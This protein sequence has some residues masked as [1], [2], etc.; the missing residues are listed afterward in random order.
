MFHRLFFLYLAIFLCVN[1][2][3]AQEPDLAF[4][5]GTRPPVSQLRHFEQVV[6]QPNQLLPEDEHALMQ[7]GSL[8][9]AYVSVGEVA[10]NSVDFAAIDQ[11]WVIG[12]N[13][14]WDSLVMDYRAE[15][16]RRYLVEK[17]FRPLWQ[18]GYRA[19]FLDTMDSYLLVEKAG[20]GRHAQEAGLRDLLRTIKAEFA[21][22]KVIVNRGFDV[23]DAAHEYIDRLVA[24][25]YFA[26]WEPQTR[27]YFQVTE[28]NRQWLHQ[29]LSRVK[30]QFKIPVTI[31]DY[32]HPGDHRTARDY[33]EKIIAAGFSPWIANG[34]LNVI[35]QGYKRLLPRRVLALYDGPQDGQWDHPLFRYVATQF[36]RL[37][38]ALDYVNLEYET[39][40]L[41]PMAG[42]YAGVVTWLSDRSQGSQAGLCVRLQNEADSGV[43]SLVLGQLPSGES[44]ARW[45]GVAHNKRLPTANL[46]IEKA[47]AS[48]AQAEGERRLRS[49]ELPDVYNKSLAASWLRLRDDSGAVFDPIFVAEFGGV[50]L[51]PY[52]LDIGADENANWLIEPITFFKTALQLPEQPQF[53]LVHENGLRIVVTSLASDGLGAAMPDATIAGA[54]WRDRLARYRF[55]ISVAVADAELN[56]STLSEQDKQ[57]RLKAVQQLLQLPNTELLTHSY[58]HPFFWRTFDGRRDYSHLNYFYTLP[59]PNYLA[60]LQREIVGSRDQLRQWLNQPVAGLLWPGDAIPGAAAIAMAEQNALLHMGGGGVRVFDRRISQANRLPLLRPSRWGIQVLSPLQDEN[61]YAR[62]FNGQALNYRDV[63]ALNQ[64]LATDRP[65]SLTLNMDALARPD[66]AA[67]VQDVIQ[68]TSAQALIGLY[69]SEYAQ[70]VRGWHAASLAQYLNG[71]FELVTEGARGVA[72]TTPMAIDWLRSNGVAGARVSGGMQRLVLTQSRV[73]L[74]A[75]NAASAW[76]LH[77]VDAPIVSWQRQDNRAR[78]R[79][80]SVA[81]VTLNVSNAEQCIARTARGEVK[82]EHKNKMVTVVLTAQQAAQE[83]DLVCH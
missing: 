67:V 25:A 27:E 66:G 79:V 52:L 11:R 46:T 63:L 54:H 76:Y 40:P 28:S 47:P 16:W 51:Q 35:G 7:T 77:S 9:V 19:F 50:A 26:G 8:I 6:V 53:D 58:S 48:L 68:Q 29:Q 61:A 18:R 64:S 38:I 3:Y 39:L 24:E 37:G 75:G 59:Q 33:A 57:Q 74:H 56:G 41:E 83:F 2:A 65:W 10:R 70:R 80:R 55:P 12:K 22:V 31:I 49:R 72:L 73:T 14:A 60:D 30:N 44:C 20:D 4:Y 13:P 71:D 69:W 78:V 36:E 34:D 21:G 81:A 23:L 32:V 15:A 45:L 62:Q 17:H 82:A 1:T 43:R 5:Y 42:R